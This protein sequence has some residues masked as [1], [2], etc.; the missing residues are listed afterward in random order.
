MALN[1][2][3]NPGDQTIYTDPTS[4]LK[5][6]Y[7]TSIG[8][9]ETA[10]QPPVIITTDGNAPDIS[11][12]GFLWWD[13]QTRVLYVLRG[14]TWAPVSS[15]GGSGGGGGGGASVTV[16][17]TPPQNAIQ[18]DLWWDSVA[19][20]LFIYY[21]D[22]DSN[23]WVIASPNVGGGSDGNIFTG[24]SAPSNPFEGQLWFNT[25]DNTIYVYNKGQWKPSSS[26]VA[27]VN[28]VT[29]AAPIFTTGTSS[30]PIIAIQAGSTTELGSMRFATTPEVQS[31][32]SA[33]AALTPSRLFNAIDAYLPQATEVRK[34]VAETATAAEA[35]A[36]TDPT[37][38]ITPATL[39]VA[40]Q[41]FGNPVGTIIAFAGEN[42]P[43]GYLLCNG[44]LLTDSASQNVQGIV[45]DFRP[46][47]NVLGTAFSSNNTDVILPDLRG[48][49]L[50]GWSAGKI[51]V[52]SGRVFGSNQTGDVQSHAHNMAAGPADVETNGQIF[53]G[54]NRVGETGIAQSNTFGGTETRPRNVAINYCIKF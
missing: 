17:D 19:G 53:G 1:F 2:P 12:D 7:N 36:G 47:R 20:N 5:Y 48:E 9:W 30:D 51:G 45:A 27:G 21:V 10:I 46:L 26:A 6:I 18:G 15:D 33:D 54:G 13:A 25:L 22:P 31:I 50:R 44:D 14:G 28:S 39:S 52:D 11:I 16:S 43:Q 32:D 4:G 29:G 40:N 37:K 34:G 8:G 38:M 49:F 42:A 3:L 23:Q 24:P 41:S 35:I